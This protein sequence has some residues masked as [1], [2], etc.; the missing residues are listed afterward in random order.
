MKKSVLGAVV[1]SLAI[2][3]SA[4]AAV[5]LNADGSLTYASVGDTSTIAFN[6]LGGEPRVVVAGLSASLALTLA[7][8]SGTTYL[9]N[10]T[11]TNTS[12]LAN[13]RVSGIGFN[14]DPNVNNVSST[15]LYDSAS[16]GGFTAG[17]ASETCFSGG[18]AQNCPQGQGNSGVFA[19]TPGSGTLSLIYAAAPASVTLSNFLDRYQ[20]FNA[21]NGI[22]SAVGQGTPGGTPT[23][24][25]TAPEATTWAMML[26]G[27][28]L[29]A[30]AM[31]RRKRQASA[32]LTYA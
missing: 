26:A 18:T 16:L 8:I 6:G 4:Q 7:S 31:R 3:S 14:V 9:F 11:L 29:V 22:T 19:G 20:G 23:Q 24:F 2:A 10:Y 13:T 25:S 30:G 12:T 21:G 28:G 15:G 1:L 27:F 32:P 5:V 17:F